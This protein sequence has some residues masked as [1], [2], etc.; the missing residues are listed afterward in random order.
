MNKRNGH[1]PKGAPDALVQR[2]IRAPKAAMAEAVRSVKPPVEPPPEEPVPLDA[3][4]VTGEIGRA[5]CRERV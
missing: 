4:D 5:S 1:Q 2:A 3:E